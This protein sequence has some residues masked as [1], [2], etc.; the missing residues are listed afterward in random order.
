MSQGLHAIGAHAT[1]AAPGS[2]RVA[3]LEGLRTFAIL[4][5]FAY[6]L[7]VFWLPSGHMGVVMFLVLTGYLVCGSLL[8]RHERSGQIDIRDFAWR[9]FKRIWPPMAVMVVLV[10]ALCVLFDHILLTKM[11]PDMLPSL[12]FFQ[13]ISAIVRGTS[14]FDQ[15]GAP[16]PLTHLWYVGLDAQLCLLLALGLKLALHGSKP[17]SRDVVIR[18]VLLAL[19]AVSAVLM[20]VFYVPGEDPSRVYYGTDT[21]AFSVLIGAWLAFVWPLGKAP[22]IG[23]HL[24]TYHGAAGVHSL[25]S[26]RR[27]SYPQHMAPRPTVGASI[28]GI[29]SLVALVLIMALIPSDSPFFYWGGM[30]LVSALVVLLLASLMTSGTLLEK[31]FSLPAIVWLGS[32]SYSLY[33]WHYPIIWLIGAH[34]GPWWMMLLALVLSLAAAEASW[35]FVENP[36]ANGQLKALIESVREHG[37]GRRGFGVPQI[38][39]SVACF[40]VLA[41]AVVGAIVTPPETLV[42]EEAIVSTGADV[43]HGMDA[44]QRQAALEKARAAATA[45]GAQNQA[46]SNGEGAASLPPDVGDIPQPNPEDGAMAPEGLDQPTIELAEAVPPAPDP[47]QIVRDLIAANGSVTLVASQAEQQAGIFDPVLIGDS[48]PGDGEDSF[49]QLMPNGLIDS[50]IGRRPDQAISV[51]ADYLEQG[52]VGNIVVFAVFS[53]TAPSL[54]QLDEIVAMTPPDKWIFLVGTV[55]P[56]GFM[57]YANAN[58]IECAN[59]YPNV[60]CVDWP[61]VVAGHESEYLWADMTHVRPEGGWAYMSAISSTIGPAFVASGGIAQ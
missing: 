55:N 5:V 56:D 1:T 12:L 6:H 7:G 25:D 30:L 47:A 28:I 42:P 43:A 59:R 54:E 52:I 51:Y 19:A 58:L 3:S 32:R 60:E 8:R 15:I 31:A 21:R 37:M 29:A 18:R 50:Y 13:N 49:Y 45:A 27:E 9:R 41:F 35:R 14:Y 4:S 17:G 34:H 44:E 48:V 61:G 23:A 22:Q 57:D 53:N 10:S 11:R 38:A 24:L 39:G 36:I 16:S 20:A 26:L 40:G 46:P 2:N 33:L